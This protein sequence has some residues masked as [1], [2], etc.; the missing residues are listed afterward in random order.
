MTD[1]KNC[2]KCSTVKPF[3][4]FYR[5]RTGKYGL[6]AYC[7]ECAKAKT[8]KY[9]E[10]DPRRKRGNDLRHKFNVTIEWYEGK[11]EE[12]GGVC[13]ICERPDPSGRSLAVDHD[14]SCCPG[15]TSCGECVRSLLCGN[16][17]TGIGKF[18]DDVQL[19]QAA[20]AY[21]GG[22]PRKGPPL[23]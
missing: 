12:Q 23:A 18:Q 6:S 4:D 7:K 5:D 15:K 16:C 21:L 3:A 8:K 1:S 22:D 2:N 17:N 10:D 20:I 14:H 13:A 9:R 19:L 11:L